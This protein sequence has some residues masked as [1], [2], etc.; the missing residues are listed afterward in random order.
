MRRLADRVLLLEGGV[1]ARS[2]TPD[3]LLAGLGLKA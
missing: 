3:E 1:I 2:G